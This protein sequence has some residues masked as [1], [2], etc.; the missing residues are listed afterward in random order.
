MKRLLDVLFSLSGLI[1]LSP[2]IIY[3]AIRVKM[4]TT[5]KVFYK[6]KRVGKHGREFYLYKFRTM[7]ANSDKVDLLTYGGD[8]PRITPFGSFLRKYKLDELPQL[9]N[10]LRGDMS[11][12]GP[13]PEVKRYTDLYT[14]D[15]R[16]ILNVRPGITD[17]ASITFIDENNLLAAQPDPEKYYIEQV[18]PEKIRLNQSFI[19]SPTLFNYLRIIA[20]TIKKIATR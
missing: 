16:K 1:L 5:G 9:F 4:D 14:V 15:Q 17:I 18:M 12:V 13:R 6:Q 8:D 2:L 10:V 20:L 19:S 3:S 11:I 7:H